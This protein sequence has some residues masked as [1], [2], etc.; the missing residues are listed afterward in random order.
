LECVPSRGDE[1]D[2]GN[3][4]LAGGFQPQVHVFVYGVGS[5]PLWSADLRTQSPLYATKLTCKRTQ[6]QHVTDIHR[7]KTPRYPARK[8]LYERADGEALLLDSVDSSHACATRQDV[9]GTEP[10]CAGVRS[11]RRVWEEEVAGETD[12]EGDDAVW[13]ERECWMNERLYGPS[14]RWCTAPTHDEQPRPT[15]Q[16]ANSMQIEYR[17][18]TAPAIALAQIS[19]FTPP[20]TPSLYPDSLQITRKHRPNTATTNKQH[21]PLP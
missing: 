13:Q 2:L 14:K 10:A 18:S 8:R 12:G 20:D 21:R 19:A 11:V 9:F 6:P 15:W 5:R 1:V 7:R 17:R 3:G 16:S 4:V